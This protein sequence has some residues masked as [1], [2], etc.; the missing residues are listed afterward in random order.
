MTTEEYLNIAGYSTSEWTV[1]SPE[2]A[3]ELLDFPG[4][5]NNMY[6]IKTPKAVKSLG[7]GHWLTNLAWMKKHSVE[8]TIAEASDKMRDAVEVIE[9]AIPSP[10]PLPPRKEPVA[11]KE[12]VQTV[13]TSWDCAQYNETHVACEEQC[14]ECKPL[15]ESF[16]GPIVEDANT[17]I[18]RRMDQIRS[19]DAITEEGEYWVADCGVRISKTIITRTTDQEFAEYMVTFQHALERKKQIESET[20]AE[21]KEPVV[22]VLGST[23]TE[24]KV[25]PNQVKA[26]EMKAKQEVK[27]KEPV[28]EKKVAKEES[29]KVSEEEKAKELN[30]DVLTGDAK[31]K[32][33]K[34]KEVEKEPIV[35]GSSKLV[36]QFE[37]LDNIIDTATQFKKTMYAITLIKNTIN[38]KDLIPA[39]K[40]AL[41][42]KAIQNI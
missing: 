37:F 21:V 24:V 1:L 15:E 3:G 28:V 26:D 30:T 8:I 13:S 5:V 9:E 22:E 12:E 14:E 36:E 10:V 39:K 29:K 18:E 23:T 25:N 27:A 40:L 16:K 2:K 20:K 7:K 33:L 11:E 38:A 31:P 19:I 6:E 34:K 41:I 17:L 42:E 32:S 4:R 35:E